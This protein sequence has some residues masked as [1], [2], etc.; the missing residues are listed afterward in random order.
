VIGGRRLLEAWEPPEQAGDPL[1]CIATSFTFDPDFFE[2]QCL[3]RFLMLDWQRDDDQSEPFEQLAAIVEQQVRFSDTAVTAVIERTEDPGKRSLKWDLL[4]VRV[5]GG[6]MHAKLS[7]L[8]W[9]GFVRFIIGS[10]NLTPA[11][12]REQIEAE[13]ILDAH[14]ESRAPRPVV[15]SALACLRTIIERTP[16]DAVDDGPQRRALA[17]LNLARRLVDGFGLPAEPSRHEPRLSVGYSEP[18][19]PALAL[20]DDVWRGGPPRWAS[21]LSPFHDGPGAAGGAAPTLASRLAK[22]GEA[23]IRFVLPT[24]TRQAATVVRAPRELARDIPRRIDVH[25]NALAGDPDEPRRLHAKA[26]SLESNSWIAAMIG[27][28]NFTRAG[29]GLG[30]AAGHLEVNFAVGAPVGSRAAKALLALI[31]FGEDIEPDEVEWEPDDEADEAC[32][33]ALPDGFAQATFLTGSEPALRLEFDLERGLPIAWSVRDPAGTAVLDAATWSSA[34]APHAQ[35]IPWNNQ[36]PVFLAV[37]WEDTDGEHSAPWPVNA[38]KPSELPLPPEL[39]LSLHELIAVLRSSRSVPDAVAHIRTQVSDR[40]GEIIRD[41][42]QRYS[43]TGQLLRRTRERTAALE[44]LRRFLERPAATLEILRWRLSGPFGPRRFAASLAEATPSRS[45]NGEVPFL[46]A[47]LA[48]TIARVDW[49][50]VCSAGL[51]RSEVKSE[52]S[53]LVGELREMTEQPT[54]PSPLGDYI[55]EAFAEAAR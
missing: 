48:L 14:P 40:D 47:E 33:D 11:G 21:V 46:M 22:R 54:A 43:G 18:G 7:L 15:L 41:P 51:S 23:G 30:R 16:P 1:G 2:I 19:R 39:R 29:L 37:H 31:P 49:A 12:Y 52:V 53:R 26:I 8:V 9:G 3:G 17:T 35:E 28:S 45:T 20:V 42:L 38:D 10:A 5:G 6:L 55:A 27:S 4:R 34:G 25:F 24:E 50:A 32:G 44:G 36:P 13:A